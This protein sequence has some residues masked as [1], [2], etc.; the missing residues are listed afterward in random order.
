[1]THAGRDGT[2]RIRAVA[3]GL[4]WVR[5]RATYLA[6]D[7]T[8]VVEFAAPDADAAVAAARS[9]EGLPGA[10]ALVQIDA[11]GADGRPVEVDLALLDVLSP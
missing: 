1:M 2:G 3:P 10:M 6:H 4:G 7:G 5:A 8:V 9:L 11:W